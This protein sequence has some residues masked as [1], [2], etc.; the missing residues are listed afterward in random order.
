MLTTMMD[1]PLLISSLLWRAEHVFADRVGVS[2]ESGPESGHGD[3]EFSYR[4]LGQA[5]RRLA[6]TFDETTASAI[7]FTSGTTGRPKGVVLS[8]RSTVRHAMAISAAGGVAIDGA[9]A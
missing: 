4:D 1:R 3:V 8:H 6:G 2:C 7:C 5:A 9:R